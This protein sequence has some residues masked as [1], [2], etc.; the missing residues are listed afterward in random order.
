MR[1][2][3]TS[4]SSAVSAS[5]KLVSTVSCKGMS[6]VAA[7][8]CV[9]GLGCTS[10]PPPPIPDPGGPFHTSVPP[11]TTLDAL[12]DTQFQELC[13]EVS[14]AQQAYLAG[15]V[16]SEG[17]CRELGV[18]DA[19]RFGPDGSVRPSPLEPGDGG[20]DGAFLS[21]CQADYQGCEQQ[22][23][24]NPPPCG[25]ILDGCGETVELLS[26]CLNEIANTNPVATCVSVPSCAQVAAAGTLRYDAGNIGCQPSDGGPSLP[27]CYRLQSHCPEA[28]GT[29]NPWY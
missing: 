21:A 15:A 18:E 14:A 24:A 5:V 8:V 27:A 3:R 11:N 20:A 29:N 9:L 22:A 4:A 1:D 19:V 2:R 12:T 16:T 25:L 17:A 10:S 23:M 28:L 7:V 13:G 26:A 6:L